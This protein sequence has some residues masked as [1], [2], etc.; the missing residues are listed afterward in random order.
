MFVVYAGTVIAPAAMI[1]SSASVHSGR[2]SLTSPTRSP[3]PIPIDSNPRASADTVS[4]A[5]RQLIAV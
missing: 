2:F 3:L 5:S 4:A 1:P